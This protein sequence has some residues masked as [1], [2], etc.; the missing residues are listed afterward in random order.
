MGMPLNKPF[1]AVTREG[2]VSILRRLHGMLEHKA[3][4]NREQF[5]DLMNAAFKRCSL[6]YVSLADDLGYSRSAVYRWVEGVTA[7]HKTLWPKI[8]AWI[9]KSIEVK[10]ADF[11]V[12]DD[13]IA[14]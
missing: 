10:I 9:M 5:S 14:N 3:I 8:V 13:V 2:E 1:T 11:S 6:E 12:M 4:E 7:P